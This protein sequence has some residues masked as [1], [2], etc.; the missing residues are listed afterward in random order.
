[1]VDGYIVA[2]P[3]NDVEGYE[4]ITVNEF[5]YAYLPDGMKGTFIQV[6]T[7]ITADVKTLNISTLEQAPTLIES[8]TVDKMY[9]RVNK[10]RGLYLA[11]RFP[12]EKIGGKDGT[13]VLEMQSLDEALVPQDDILIG[14]RYIEPVSKRIE[15]TLPGDWNN[16]G[17]VSLR[18][19]DPFHF[20]IVSIIPDV[21]ILTR[22]NR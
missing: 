5:G 21:E 16:Q 2:S 8:F 12:E 6:G 20:E 22:S 10:T 11:N 15:K 9:V 4:E 7:P 18:Q 17:Q 3:N 19:V 14:N 1:M 13:S